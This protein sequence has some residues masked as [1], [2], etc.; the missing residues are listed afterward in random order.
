MMPASVQGDR[1]G[2]GF[3]K[4]GIA[5]EMLRADHDGRTQRSTLPMAMTDRL[6]AFAHLRAASG[7]WPI[8]RPIVRPIMRPNQAGR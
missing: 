6:F 8:M 1:A 3:P 2:S 7:G 5:H 4:V